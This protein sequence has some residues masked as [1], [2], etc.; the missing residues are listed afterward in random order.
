[1][2]KLGVWQ[3]GAGR[4]ALRRSLGRDSDGVH[5][6][7][8]PQGSFPH[9]PCV[10]EAGGGRLQGGAGNPF[11]ASEGSGMWG[12]GLGDRHRLY[13]LISWENADPA[14][15]LMQLTDQYEYFH[16][17]RIQT[18]VGT[19]NLLSGVGGGGGMRR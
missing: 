6:Q 3:D 18:S 17:L 8:G 11:C 15:L 4:N 1:M 19:P 12:A 7:A 14:L 5:R 10:W 2:E 13:H 16:Q 9:L